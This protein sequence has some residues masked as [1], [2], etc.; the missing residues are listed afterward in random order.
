MKSCSQGGVHARATLLI[1]LRCRSMGLQDP[2]G[3]DATL[4]ISR[5]GHF[6]RRVFRCVSG[7][8]LCLLGRHSPVQVQVV[9]STRTVVFARY[10]LPAKRR[11]TTRTDCSRCHRVLSKEIGQ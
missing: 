10:V 5:R 1:F 7:R 6:F 8:L 11:T 3:G 9:R 4:V 2:R